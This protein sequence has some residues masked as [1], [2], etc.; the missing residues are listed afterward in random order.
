MWFCYFL[1]GQELQLRRCRRWHQG[2]PAQP[3]GVPGAECDASLRGG[4]VAV[5][6]AHQEEAAVGARGLHRHLEAH[7]E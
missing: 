6:D 7:Q 4:Y 2:G 1:I 3:P 5:D